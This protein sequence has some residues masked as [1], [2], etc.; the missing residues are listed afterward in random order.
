MSRSPRIGLTSAQFPDAHLGRTFNG[1]SRAYTQGV[2]QAGGLPVLLPVL[3]DLAETYARDVDAV[4]FT[5]GVDLHPSLYAEHARRG[6]GEVDPERDAFEVALYRA[7]RALGKPTFG[8]CRGFQLINAL[9]GGTLHQHL[10]D[11]DGVWADHAQLSRP[12]VLAHAMTFTPGSQLARTH[13]DGQLVNSYHHQ[14]V[15]DLAPTL[16][17]TAFAPDGLIEG[18]EGEGILAVQWHPELTFQTHPDTFGTFTAFL[19]SM[20]VRA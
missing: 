7:A 20:G 11:A 6:L 17:A 2:A 4:L 8:I 14:G 19:A 1:T 5:G 12:P 10:P 15:R 3:P 13:T 18:V 9:E 16:T